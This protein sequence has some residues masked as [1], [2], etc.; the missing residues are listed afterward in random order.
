MLLESPDI[1]K[2][3]PASAMIALLKFHISRKDVDQTIRV[4]GVMPQVAMREGARGINLI[5]RMY[6]LMDWD[7]KVR[8][9]VLGTAAAVMYAS[10]RMLMH[11][12]R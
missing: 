5:G 11:A 3:I 9:R 2:V 7:E 4:A 6:K 12:K 8:M 10:R 1:A